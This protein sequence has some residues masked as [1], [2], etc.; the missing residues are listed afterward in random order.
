MCI[1]VEVEGP[2]VCGLA[3]PVRLYAPRSIPLAPLEE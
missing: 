2:V 3:S 1:A